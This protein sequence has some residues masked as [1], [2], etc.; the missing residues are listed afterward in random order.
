MEIRVLDGRLLGR[1]KVPFTVANLEF[2]GRNGSQMFICASHTLFTIATN[3]RGA[4]RLSSAG[5]R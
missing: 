5:P 2:G 3:T 4:P 1:I